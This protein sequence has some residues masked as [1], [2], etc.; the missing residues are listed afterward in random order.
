MLTDVD[1]QQTFSLT[2]QV[3]AAF[4]FLFYL[5]YTFRHVAVNCQ[6]Q[7]MYICGMKHAPTGEMAAVTWGS[8]ADHVG[9][10]K[11]GGLCEYDRRVAAQESMVLN[12]TATS[13]KLYEQQHAASLAHNAEFKTTA[14]SLDPSF[15]DHDFVRTSRMITDE[16]LEKLRCERENLLQVI[17]EFIILLAFEHRESSIIKFILSY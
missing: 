4:L 13:A 14:K 11:H 8:A 9:G 6:L 10:F 2:Y 5:C 17:I 12:L 1:F 16:E 15:E 7:R 3:S